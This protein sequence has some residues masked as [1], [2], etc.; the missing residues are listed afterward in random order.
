MNPTTLEEAL[1]MVPTHWPL[2]S[3]R[4]K[5][6]KGD[7]YF[8]H[9]LP[10]D[11]SDD[12][13]VDVGPY[14]IESIEVVMPDELGRRPIPQDVRESAAWWLLYNSLAKVDPDAYGTLLVYNEEHEYIDVLHGAEKIKVKSGITYKGCR[15]T[16][17]LRKFAT[18]RE[19]IDAVHKLGGVE[20]IKKELSAGADP[21]GRWVSGG[22]P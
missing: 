8:A 20:R 15:E 5:W 3:R 1:S 16:N 10:F 12:N 22:N 7:Q 2:S 11:D 14:H 21:L 9:N 6:Q 17:G 19:A 13:W 18:V 4:D